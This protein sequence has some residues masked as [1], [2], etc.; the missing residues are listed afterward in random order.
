[1]KCLLFDYINGKVKIDKFVFRHSDK[2]K[3]DE[4]RMA[5]MVVAK[6]YK[7]KELKNLSG[8]ILLITVL[9]QEFVKDYKFVDIKILEK[10]DCIYFYIK[11]IEK[12]KPMERRII[13]NFI[14]KG[15][16]NLFQKQP[17]SDSGENVHNNK[18]AIDLKVI[19]VDNTF[20]FKEKAPIKKVKSR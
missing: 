15:I 16:I 12:Y 18:D 9:N 7:I 1:M 19:L 20:L 14:V 11:D 13:F 5:E 4:K 17:I 10:E 8:K 2:N 3:Y 6:L